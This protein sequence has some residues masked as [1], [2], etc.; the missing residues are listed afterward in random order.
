MQRQ[1][2]ASGAFRE[3]GYDA[4]THVME[5]QFVSG[6]VYQ[7]FDVPEFEHHGLMLARSKGAYFAKR[8]QGRFRFEEVT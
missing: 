5:L 8:I 3:V 6:N 1:P 2:V 4:P 7:F